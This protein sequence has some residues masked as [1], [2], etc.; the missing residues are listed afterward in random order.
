MVKINAREIVVRHVRCADGVV[1][2][3]ESTTLRDAKE[4]CLATLRAVN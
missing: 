3:V 2:K 4:W 1:G